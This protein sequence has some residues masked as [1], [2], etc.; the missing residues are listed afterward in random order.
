MMPHGGTRSW[1]AMRSEIAQLFGI[2]GAMGG[3]F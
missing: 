2:F 1:N 3:R